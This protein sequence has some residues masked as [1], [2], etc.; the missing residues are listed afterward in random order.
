MTLPVF[1]INL[2]RR[3]DRWAAMSAQLDRLGIEATRVAGIDGR[4]LVDQDRWEHGNDNQ[5]DRIVGIGDEACTLSHYKA[6]SAFLMTDAPAALIL[7]DDTELSPDTPG[8]LSDMDWW[9]SQLSGLVKI[10]ATFEL[11]RLLGQPIGRTS[12]GRVLRELYRWNGGAGAYMVN[13]EAARTILDA[14]VPLR[15]PIDH[16]IFNRVDSGTARKLRPVQVCP[17]MAYQRLDDFE[18]DTE[19][20]RITKQGWKDD[21]RTARGRLHRAGFWLWTMQMRARG[22][23]RKHMLRYSA[24]PNWEDMG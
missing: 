24:T 21:R 17:A 7:E 13:R 2:D 16:L 6:L 12:S 1:V 20:T 11:R 18:S 23:A 3:P 10:E 5:P 14:G 15:M 19:P 22:K 9:P 4:L 8:L